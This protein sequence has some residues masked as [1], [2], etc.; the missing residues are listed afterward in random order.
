M[1]LYPPVDVVLYVDEGVSV[2]VPVRCVRARF[3]HGVHCYASP[4]N[5]DPA[6]ANLETA[7]GLAAEVNAG[8]EMTNM[9]LGR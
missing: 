3:Y 6:R 8:G 7:D 9:R 4:K 2:G 5:A 1:S